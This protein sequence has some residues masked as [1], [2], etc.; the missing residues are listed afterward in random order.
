MSVLNTLLVASALFSVSSRCL[1]QEIEVNAFKPGSVYDI[2]EKIQWRITVTGEGAAAVEKISYIV[3]MGDRTEMSRGELTLKE[4]GAELE[5]RLNEAGTV[6]AELT[7]IVPDKAPIKNFAGAVVAP[8]RIGPSSPPPADFDAFWKRKLEELAAVPANPVLEA[9]ESGN[10]NVDYWKISL[11]N[12]RGSKIRG[13]LARPKAGAKLPALLIVQWAGVYPLV[14]GWATDKAREGWLTLNINAHDLP[15]DAPADFYKQQSETTLRD[16]PGIGNDDRETS[17]FLRMYLSCYRAADYLAGR[18][19]WDG[20]TL[21]VMGTSQGG[22]QA[23]MTGGF[24]PKVTALLANVPAGTDHTGPLV[25]RR[26]GW[27]QWYDKT[28]NKDAARVIETSRYFDVVNFAS[29][30]K[31]PAL[32]SAGLIDRT[33]PPAGIIAA[34]NQIQA[35]KELLLME[36]SDHQGR[37]N[38]QAAFYARSGAW[39]KQLAAGQS[40]VAK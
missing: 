22:L 8:D 13:Q 32:I 34:F 31:S 26:G 15:I 6:L 25:G 12:I 39:L 16:Y 2:G 28:Q 29:R 21:V 3:R 33:C 37:N 38:S 17:Y 30:I 40:P 4:G 1:A 18:D 10:P 27:P 19:D 14:K 23:I 24:H 7:A 35:P 11:D 36:K 9:G 5:T 20:K